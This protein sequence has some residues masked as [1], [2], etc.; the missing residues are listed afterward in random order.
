MTVRVLVT[1]AS[2]Y[3]GGVIADELRAHGMEVLTAG[4]APSNDI[5][6]DLSDP[7]GLAA[8]KLPQGLHAC[9]H[10]AAMHEVACRAT[11]SLAYVVNVAGTRALLDAC[12]RAGISRHAYV[13]TFHVFGRPEGHLDEASAVAPLNDYGLTHWQAEQLY[14]LAAQTQGMS[15]DIL[16]PANLFGLPAHWAGFDRWTLAPFDFCRQA[17]EHGRIALHGQGTAL[18]NY[19]SAQHLARVLA[20]RLAEPGAGVL[21][22][23]GA[24]WRIR[25]LANLAASCASASLGREVPVVFGT[26]MESAAPEYQFASRHDAAESGDARTAMAAFLFGTLAHLRKL[27]T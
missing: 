16:R 17:V 25:D 1:G 2:G 11:P 9:V 13:S 26:A 27:Q 6:L 23:A 14:T 22:V 24:E 21:H 3:A 8:M 12:G 15:V 19:L 5:K 20:S 18:R 7:A 4:R 10:A